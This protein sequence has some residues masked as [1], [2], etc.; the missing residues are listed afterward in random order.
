MLTVDHYLQMTAAYEAWADLVLRFGQAWAEYL[1]ERTHKGY[2]LDS[3][4]P[5]SA[6]IVDGEPAVIVVLVFGDS[7]E[8]EQRDVFQVALSTVLNKDGWAAYFTKQRDDEERR[9]TEMVAQARQQFFDKQGKYP[10]DFIRDMDWLV[11]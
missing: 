9:Y 11:K 5:T 3:W 6:N 4:Q 1:E 10:E 8:D 2:S 7:P